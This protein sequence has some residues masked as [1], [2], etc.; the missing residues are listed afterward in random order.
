MKAR[1]P[2]A[3]GQHRRRREW[4]MTMTWCTLWLSKRGGGWLGRKSKKQ[5]WPWLLISWVLSTWVTVRISASLDMCTA[6][7]I[8][9]RVMLSRVFFPP[10]PPPRTTFPNSPKTSTLLSLRSTSPTLFTL[11]LSSS[12]PRTLVPRL[13]LFRLGRCLQLWVCWVT[14]SNRKRGKRLVE[15]RRWAAFVTGLLY[16]TDEKKA[17]SKPKLGAAKVLSKVDTEAYDDVLGDDDFM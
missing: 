6:A 4:T 15:R 17:A 16:M 13:P 11:T 1:R 8:L 10:I 7:N 5:T 12:L 14:P 9:Q 3:D 2:V